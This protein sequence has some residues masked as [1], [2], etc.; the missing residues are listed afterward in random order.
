[1]PRNTRRQMRRMFT[2]RRL[3]RVLMLFLAVIGA[4]CG[5]TAVLFSVNSGTIVDS[6][7]CHGTSGSF[8]MRD[9]GGL[10]VL[11][12]VTS[13][14]RVLIS[15]GTLGTCA[16]LVPDSHVGVTGLQRGDRLTARSVT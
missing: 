16:D 13:S 3:G 2:M 15:G 11:V 10:V 7:L 12:V 9:Q 4:G 8:T 14:T 6:P 1:M 5:D